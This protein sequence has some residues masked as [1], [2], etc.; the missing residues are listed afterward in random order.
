MVGLTLQVVKTKASL[1]SGLRVASSNGVVLL[2]P[3]IVLGTL[4]V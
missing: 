2:A 1:R 4:Y 3:G